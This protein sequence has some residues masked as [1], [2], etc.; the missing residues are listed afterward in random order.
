MYGPPYRPTDH[1]LLKNTTIE[2]SER[3]VTRV[4]E[5]DYK[6]SDTQVVLSCFY[7]FLQVDSPCSCGHFEMR[8]TYVGRLVPKL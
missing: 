3:L 2:H 4:V 1:T 6:K 8:L 5:S 7:P